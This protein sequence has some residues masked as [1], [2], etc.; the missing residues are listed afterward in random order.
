SAVVQAVG[1]QFNVYEHGDNTEVAVLE[2]RVRVLGRA[3]NAALAQTLLDKG[4]QAEIDRAGKIIKRVVPDA[5]PT[6]AW[7]QR[8]LVFRAAPLAEVAE[9]FNRYN[10]YQIRIDDEALRRRLIWGVFQ[11]D[12]P[13]ALVKFLQRDPSL[14]PQAVPGGLLVRSR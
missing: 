8:R 9:E 5:G 3:D 12:E 13:Q 1:T 14:D 10:E 7:Q 4:E 6:V 11:A 2:G